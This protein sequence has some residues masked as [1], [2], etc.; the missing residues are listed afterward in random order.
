MNWTK[1][2]IIRMAH[3]TGLS[4]SQVYKWCWDQKKKQH[5]SKHDSC[6]SYIERR[7]IIKKDIS[8]HG[9]G[10][11]YDDDNSDLEEKDMSSHYLQTKLKSSTQI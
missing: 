6:K 1:E 2:K 5:K 3:F 11:K 8:Y 9:K 4:Q 10:Y 7:K